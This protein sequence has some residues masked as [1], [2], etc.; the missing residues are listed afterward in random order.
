MT[1]EEE[2]KA[3]AEE[4]EAEAEE[5]KAAAEEEEAEAE[6]KKKKG[7]GFWRWLKGAGKKVGRTNIPTGSATGLFIFVLALHLVD[8]FYGR[9][10][11]NAGPFIFLM[12]I[13]FY[14]LVSFYA[15]SATGMSFRASLGLSAVALLLPNFI[16]LLTKLMPATFVQGASLMLIIMPIWP[17]FLL[18][19]HGDKIGKWF[20]R[21]G[22]LYIVF[23][24]VIF[25]LA[26]SG[27]IKATVSELGAQEIGGV[28][29]GTVLKD[30]W[31][32]AK[33][34]IVEMY[35]ATVIYKQKTAEQ[36]QSLGYYEGQVDTKAKEKLGV[37]FGE[38]Q[39]TKSEYAPGESVDVFTTL[40]AQ[41]LENALNITLGCNATDLT[42]D[43]INITPRREISVTTYEQPS[44]DCI[45]KDGFNVS[46]KTT[47]AKAVIL[48]ADFSFT[49]MAY[50]RTYFM[51]K[52]RMIDLRKLSIDP[53]T[54]YG[55]TDR[56]PRAISTAGPVLIGMSLG[57]QLPIGIDATT[58]QLTLGVTLSNVWEGKL[59]SIDK[60]V[61]VIPSGLKL[62]MVQPEGPSIEDS[63]C[64]G[65]SGCSSTE[66]KV[67]VIKNIK[68]PELLSYTTI[69]V[70]LNVV[71]IAT[72]LGDSPIA[73]KSIWAIAYYG[74][75]L[76]KGRTVTVKG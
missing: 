21:L 4:E 29:P 23:W 22:W 20:R 50:L 32:K 51:D 60:L 17:V 42:Q 34:G 33:E 74:Y 76:E 2:K 6:E 12:L 25:F 59:K 11:G 46:A 61:L 75:R 47:E 52:T 24:I 28:Q 43:K 62:T 69:R 66:Q 72:L 53:L 58:G 26:Y 67:Y 40:T 39:S 44:I 16:A 57:D 31:A 30:V 49:T 35:N 37:Y 1:E 56:N 18:L 3:A 45:I 10:S 54:Q 41:T 7:G 64:T 9:L 71:D 13:A 19:G 65:I 15:P 68:M 36:I 14:L 55:I 8:L 5:R 48:T 63:D 70:F 27:P 73:I 38:I